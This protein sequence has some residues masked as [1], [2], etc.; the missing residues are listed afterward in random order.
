[1]YN[2]FS[3]FKLFI[4]FNQMKRSKKKQPGIHICLILQKIVVY[5]CGN[6]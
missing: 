6:F 1:M 4:L 5:E 2:I 3:D